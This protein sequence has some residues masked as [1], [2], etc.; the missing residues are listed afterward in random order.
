MM[1]I[2]FGVSHLEC[3]QCLS[4]EPRRPWAAVYTQ[5]CIYPGCIPI[6]INLVACI[7]PSS[8]PDVPLPHRPSGRE[9]GS[10]CFCLGDQRGREAISL[11]K[12]TAAGLCP[13]NQDALTT[14]ARTLWVYIQ[15]YCLYLELPGHFLMGSWVLVIWI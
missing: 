4:P 11:P 3:Q 10:Q 13:K 14:W 12:G 9:T 8:Y 2:V 6:H 5:K 1:M 15:D 7:L